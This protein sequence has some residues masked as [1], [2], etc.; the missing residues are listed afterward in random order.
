MIGEYGISVRTL[1]EYVHRSGSIDLRFRT[2]TSMIEGT[3]AHQKIQA[4]Y[5]KNDQKEIYLHTRIAC[6]EIEFDIEGRCDGLLFSDSA[7]TIDEIKST[8][9]DLVHVTENSHPVHWAQAK[10]YAYMY[11]IGHGL[12][13]INIQLTYVQVEAEQIK[14]FQ[15][16]YTV[17]ELRQFIHQMVEG[18]Y[19]FAKWQLQHIAKRNESIGNATFPFDGYRKG[20]RK[21]AGAVLKRSRRKKVYLQALLPE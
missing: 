6:R 5:A 15:Q 19:P 9:G 11:A 16:I 8:S 21:L 4:Q 12:P 20:Q 1:V 17:E 10:C 2:N 7:V 13:E 18:Y 3:K 14:R